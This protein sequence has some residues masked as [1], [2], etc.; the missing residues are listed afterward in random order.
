MNILREIV[1]TL[2]KKTCLNNPE[3]STRKQAFKIGVCQII[4]GLIVIFTNGRVIGS[5]SCDAIEE[6]ILSGIN[7]RRIRARKE[8]K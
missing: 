7:R 3:I 1:K 5:F 6:A 4:D 2:K 8:D